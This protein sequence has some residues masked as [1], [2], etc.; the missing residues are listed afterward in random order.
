MIQKTS[1]DIN[2]FKEKLDQEKKRLEEELR[3]V[4]RVNPANPK[5]WEATP[6]PIEVSLAD[7]TEVAEQIEEFEGRSAVEVELENNLESIKHAL[8]RIE[9]GMYGT[10]ET[11]NESIEVERLEANP[12]A[13]TCLKH[14]NT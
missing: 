14:I 2:H 13:T 9:K 1:I 11:G 6:P 4:G 12:A 5:D 3:S 8:E 7:K 10:C